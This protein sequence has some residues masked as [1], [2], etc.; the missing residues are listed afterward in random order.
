MIHVLTADRMREADRRTIEGGVT[1]LVLMENA[2]K[3]VAQAVTSRYPAARHP[4]ILCGKGSNGGDG[5]VAAR[6][7]LA[8]APKVALLGE[9]AQVRGDAR[10]QLVALEA[11]GGSVEEIA[12]AAGWERFRQS[13]DSADL[14]VD[15]LLGTGLR[16]RPA[17]VVALAVADL[18]QRSSARVPIVAVDIPSGVSSDT[19][20]VPWVTVSA[21]LTVTFG[22]PKVGHVLA[23]AC[24]RCGEL[25]VA[26]IGI[27]AATIDGLAPHLSL[28][29]RADVRS[30]F[31]PRRAASHKGSYGH[32][33]IIGGS[34]GKTGAAGLAAAGALRSGVGLVTIATP[35]PAVAAVAAWRAEAMT[36]PLPASAEGTV[37][38]GGVDRALAA[39]RERDAVV[40]GP[41]LGLSESSRDFV[42]AFVPRCPVPLL[43]DADG[44]NAISAGDRMARGKLLQRHLP[45]VVTPHPGEMAR[46]I[47]ATVEE[48]QRRR[49]ETA[50]AL[51]NE[52]GAVVVLKGQRTLVARPHG[53]V[54]V[55]PT[56]NAGMATGGTGDVL[57]GMIGA[58][59][60][61]GAEAW[62]AACAGVFL[63]GAAGDVG[64]ERMGQESLLA[65]DVVDALP[66][67][68]RRLTEGRG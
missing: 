1:G 52:T 3:A 33:L 10:A 48:V 67:A 5:F 38:R 19:G 42:G 26:D 24:D 49:V 68:F 29:E 21:T 20:D 7:L 66:E 55:N 47:G 16:D 61:R 11:A 36:E 2:G 9:R 17:G 35:A 31:P 46:L 51:A 6:H 58:L 8:L 37:D 13:L 4:A 65:M 41:G 34:V 30:A 14:I 39:A 59:L 64:A 50:G 27:P 44:L 60:A 23:P 57:A 12:D 53:S 15:A 32:L 18:A 28:L 63:H 25:I 22:A 54:A 45:T 56:G 62:A 43:V 40:L